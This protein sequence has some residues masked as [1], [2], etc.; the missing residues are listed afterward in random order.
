MEQTILIDKLKTTGVRYKGYGIIPKAVMLDTDLTIQAKAIYAYFS[1]YSG[2][3]ETAFPGRDKIVSDLKLN[4]DTYYKHFNML[5]EHGLI[6]VERDQSDDSSRFSRNIYTLVSSP[7]KYEEIKREPNQIYAKGITALGYG[8]IPKAVMTDPRLSIK[9]KGLYAYLCSFTGTGCETSPKRSDIVYHLGINVNS[10]T[11]YKKELHDLNFISEQQRHEGGKLGSVDII[12]NDTPDMDKITDIG[13]KV[14]QCT[15][16]SDME[17]SDRVSETQFDSAVQ[18]TN[19]SDMKNQDMKK[20]DMVNSDTNNNNINN[21]NFN[22]NS[23]KNNKER[24]TE[25]VSTAPALFTYSFS[26][27]G[28]FEITEEQHQSLI[29]SYEDTEKLFKLCLTKLSQRK[30]PPKNIYAYILEVA[31]ERNW[32]E[33]ESSVE[34][35]GGDARAVALEKQAEQEKRLD[36]EADHNAEEA[37]L[38]WIKETGFEGSR[39]EAQEERKRLAREKVMK[40]FGLRL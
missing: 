14:I 24:E 20:Q 11:K 15:K 33:K 37:L 16:F 19:F 1:S 28:S 38:A 2:G 9:A 5:I 27:L 13:V 39:E 26:G 18:C 29:N 23:F 17:I 12:V 10:Y 4:K 35:K 32:K 25:T 22:N 31:I 6:I 8:Y 30:N 40:Q 21:N 34:G 7:K 36:E 3:G